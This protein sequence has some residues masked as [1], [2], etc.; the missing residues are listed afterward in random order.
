MQHSLNVIHS[1]NLF[2]LHMEL[3]LMVRAIWYHNSNV[4]KFNRHSPNNGNPA[5]FYRYHVPQISQ[6]LKEQ[7]RIR[8]ADSALETSKNNGAFFNEPIWK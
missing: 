8:A 5:E 4:S 6:R 2:I 1:S 3:R 7:F